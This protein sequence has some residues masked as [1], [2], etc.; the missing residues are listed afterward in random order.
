MTEPSAQATQVLGEH[1][2]PC[3]GCGAPLAAD[4]RY[5]LNC[6]ARRGEPRVEYQEHLPAA[7]GAA[8]REAQPAAPAADP[9]E[10]PPR[11][12]APLAAVGGIA[13][14]GL[15]LLVGVLIGRGSGDEAQAPPPVVRVTG[16]GETTGGDGAGA[17]ANASKR[18]N[19]K[20]KK[21]A[22]PFAGSRGGTGERAV[23]ASDE[24]LEAL[25]EQSPEA[26]QRASARLPDTIATG[27][28]PPPT[29][30][31]EPGG[32]SGGAVIR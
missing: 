18:A 1:G 22:G 7:N 11:D 16:G 21:N 9:A 17:S 24:D 27:G 23:T 32:G 30:N 14:L 26:Y 5:C 28:E 13:V 6:G 2:E 15:M 25:Q 19:G 20:S 12:Y 4:Q 31:V 3:R 29:D 10:R 8:P